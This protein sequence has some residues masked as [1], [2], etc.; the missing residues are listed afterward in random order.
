VRF[1]MLHGPTL[2]AILVTHDALDDIEGVPP[3]AGGYLACFNKHR[4]ALELAASAKH[5]RGQ[6]E[7]C[8]SVIVEPG[9]L[10]TSN[11]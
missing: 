7:E 11:L 2:V 5:Q 3:G 1:G 10:R 9:D 8:G 6:L 4:D